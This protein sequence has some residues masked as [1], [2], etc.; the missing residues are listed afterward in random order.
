MTTKL[1]AFLERLSATRNRSDLQTLVENVRE[2][3]D[4]ENVVYHAINSDGDQFAALTYDPSW[5][6]H[7]R[8]QGYV[9]TDPVVLG[10][11]RRFQPLDWKRLDWSDKTSREMF[12][13]F[14]SA[15]MGNQ[16]YTVP[17]RGPRGQFAMFTVNATINDDKWQVFTRENSRDMLLIS[18][19]LHQKAL[20]IVE[21]DDQLTSKEL[22]PR[23][24]DALSLL[25]AGMSRGRVAEQ[26]AISEHTLR[27]YIDTARAKLG[28]LNTTHA[29][30]IAH[31][32]G[33]IVF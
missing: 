23:E 11:L 29:I 14:F 30:A 4:V 31:K 1:E 28:A 8:E 26:L 33:Q 24:R 5:E 12:S 6:P 10:A 19:Y 15:G 22:S 16:G 25:A 21:P 32:K 3:Y 27:V 2:V 18:H 13:E 9:R 17:I 20:E 7:Y